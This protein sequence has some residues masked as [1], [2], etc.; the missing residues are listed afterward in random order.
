[1]RNH[2]PMCVCGHSHAAHEPDWNK[3]HKE[4]S[5]HVCSCKHIK[6]LPDCDCNICDV[7]IAKKQVNKIK[8]RWVIR[9]PV[10]NTGLVQGEETMYCVTCLNEAG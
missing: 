6:H 7:M 10:H 2:N 1:M 9:C 8:K 5:C 4:W 3:D